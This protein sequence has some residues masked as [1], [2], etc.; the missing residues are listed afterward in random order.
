[1]LLDGEL[2]AASRDVVMFFPF[3]PQNVYVSFHPGSEISIHIWLAIFAGFQLLLCQLP[4]LHHLRHLNAVATFA[5][6]LFAV[7][8]ATGCFINGVASSAMP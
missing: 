1:M 5:T 4:T 7:I 8:T 3:L 6:L 2:R